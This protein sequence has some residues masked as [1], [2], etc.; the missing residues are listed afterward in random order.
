MTETPIIPVP[1]ESDRTPRAA[2]ILAAG[3]GTRMRSALPKVL[4]PVGGRP[5]LHWALA[6]ARAAGAERIILVAGAHSGEVH[7]EAAKF[8][9]AQDIVIQ[10]PPMGTG[11]AVSCARAALAEFEGDALVIFADTPLIPPETAERLFAAVAGDAS[12]AVL[13][14]RPADPGEYGRLV[15]GA[16]GAL[17]RIVEARDANAAEKLI[18]LCN[19][20]VMA[21]PAKLLFS[22]LA[23]VTNHNA[24]GEYYLTDIVGLAVG[25]GL[26]ARVIETA[27]E[28]V[29]GVNS[30]ADLAAAEAVFQSRK[31]AEMLAHGISLQA[32]D[33]VHFSWDTEIAPD[34][35]VEPFVVFGP[36]VTIATG[37]EIRA[38]SHLEGANVR[39]GARIGP[40]ARLRKGADIGGHAHIGNFVEVKNVRIGEGAK[41]NHLAY[42][43]DGTV[44]AGANIGAGVVFCNYD[45]YD[46]YQTHVGAGAFI[47]SDCALVAPVT[48]G[49][50]AYTGSGS[51]ITDDVPEDALALARGRQILREGWAAYFRAEKR[52]A[53]D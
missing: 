50:G 47:G 1:S 21:A 37:A 46:K 13:G 23:R 35:L 32:P 22:L 48:I 6:L 36:G 52:G 19:S 49:A 14:F 5:M 40:F 3:H 24:K 28:D 20:G 31:R 9:P 4:H 30:R 18:P 8:L 16:N 7:A 2:I 29:L 38:F 17:E 11:H 26:Q 44:G 43:G 34:V 39:E 51:V 45:G 53:K 41:A 10:D 15:T 12:V 42:L 25:D 27:A 33:S